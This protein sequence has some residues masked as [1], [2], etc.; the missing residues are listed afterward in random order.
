M[1][2]RGFG[3]GKWNGFGGKVDDEHGEKVIDAAIREIGE[4]TES[5]N[6]QIGVILLPGDLN[7]VAEIDFR[8]EQKPEWSQKVHVFLAYNWQGQPNESEEMRPQ[9]YDISEIPYED[10]WVDDEYWLPRVLSGEKITALFEFNENQ[11]LLGYKIDSS[12]FPQIKLK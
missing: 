1:K 2:K 7:K 10:M 6:G 3:V 12:D 5:E 9:W 4:E 8:F 11:E